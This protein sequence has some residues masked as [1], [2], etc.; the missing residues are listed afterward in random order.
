M[1]YI[2]EDKINVVE[3][4]NLKTR[5]VTKTTKVSFELQS[6]FRTPSGC[7]FASCLKSGEE[8]YEIVI[9]KLWAKKRK[10]AVIAVRK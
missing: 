6:I 7:W 10:V 3:I 8:G 9:S 5:E 1:G 4:F 2:R